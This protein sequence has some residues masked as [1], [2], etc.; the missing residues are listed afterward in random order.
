M[1]AIDRG[2]SVRTYR[3]SA[4]HSH[5]LGRACMESAEEV[6]AVRGL[7]QLE[8]SVLTSHTAQRTRCLFPFQAL[9]DS[10]SKCRD[11]GAEVASLH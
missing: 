1:H 8:E 3:R 5:I 11:S 4:Q 6:R 2:M 9:D 7:L 10:R